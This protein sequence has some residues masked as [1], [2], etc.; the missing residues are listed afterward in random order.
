ME[1]CLQAK[2]CST[3]LHEYQC[4]QTT[5]PQTQLV[6]QKMRYTDV[7]YGA[8][9]PALHLRVVCVRCCAVST[10]VSG[11]TQGTVHAPG[12]SIK[13]AALCVC[14]LPVETK[15]LGACHGFC[16]HLPAN[17]LVVCLLRLMLLWKHTYSITYTT[18]LQYT[19]YTALWAMF[20]FSSRWLVKLVGERST[21]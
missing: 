11:R 8:L 16:N 3:S 13:A 17:P 19:T 9:E 18:L 10:G 2:Y 15:R 6:K 1:T 7:Y 5:T 12:L 20:P 21:T 14:G 4:W